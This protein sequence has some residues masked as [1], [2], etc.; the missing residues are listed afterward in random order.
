MVAGQMPVSAA[1]INCKLPKTRFPT[2]LLPRAGSSSHA[3]YPAF[4][5]RLCVFGRRQLR[6]QERLKAAVPVS[7]GKPSRYAVGI[8]LVAR[9][10]RAVELSAP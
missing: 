3:Q 1:A 4:H 10:F 5:L 9:P 6:L 8:V 2:Y 7:A